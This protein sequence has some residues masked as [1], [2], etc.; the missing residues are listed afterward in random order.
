MDFVCCNT[1][2]YPI[3][4][5]Y[6]MSEKSIDK[7]EV[8]RKIGRNVVV[9]QKMEGLLKKLVTIQG[10]TISVNDQENFH[11]RVEAVAKKPLGHLVSEFLRSAYSSGFGNNPAQGAESHATISLSF[12]L[13]PDMKKEHAE[14]LSSVVKERNT[15]I[16]QML[17]SFDPNSVSGR[18]S[19]T[20]S[21]DDQL[22]RV[23]PEYQLLNSLLA[24]MQQALEQAEREFEK[25]QVGGKS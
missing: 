12:S 15:L 20:R 6:Q 17:I 19:L 22:D 13:D 21:L 16:H 2:P 4:S 24:G 9:L 1:A 25:D 11:R 5:T 18:E 3:F 7:D 8:L 10:A 14:S 23:L